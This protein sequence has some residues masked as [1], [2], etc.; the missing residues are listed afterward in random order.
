MCDCRKAILMA[1]W[2]HDPELRPSIDDLM[3]ILKS[4]MGLLMPCLDAP[5]SAVAMEGTSACE[6]AIPNNR[7]SVSSHRLRVAM[8]TNSEHAHLHSAISQ[9][10]RSFPQSPTS[11]SGTTDPFSLLTSAALA[12][13]DR[14]SRIH[15]DNAPS[16]EDRTETMSASGS[17][18][19]VDAEED[20]ETPCLQQKTIDEGKSSSKSSSP[21]SP[22]PMRYIA[23]H[24]NSVENERSPQ[25][26][27][28]FISDHSAKEFWHLN[29]TSVV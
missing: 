12:A 19:D 14:R 22:I 9:D 5:L 16:T 6:V 17:D 7:Q 15:S 10:G 2:A 28:D 11:I 18:G 20:A 27:S 8:R 1:C 13:S 24:P 23:L 3:V 21:D 25:V 29:G 4:S 26:G